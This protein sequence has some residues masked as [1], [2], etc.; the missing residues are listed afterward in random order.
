MEI[1]PPNNARYTAISRSVSTT[2]QSNSGNNVSPD[3]KVSQL[4]DALITKITDKQLFLDIQG[5]RANT[6]RPANINLHIGDTLKLQIE[7]LKPM[8][9]FRIIRFQ[10]PT[11]INVQ[12]NTN[13]NPITDSY[14]TAAL[15]K[16]ISYVAS[17]PALRPSPL[18][19]E[20]NAAVLI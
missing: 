3:W 2:S 10:T 17:R 1:K 4:L 12:S 8:P 15:L 19:A 20:T 14:Q 11:N 7:Q 18:T 5:I 13:K 6:L 9:Q 16:N